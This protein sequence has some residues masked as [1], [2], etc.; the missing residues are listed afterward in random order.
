M[1]PAM[2]ANTVALKICVSGSAAQ[3]VTVKVPS[4]FVAMLSTA[5]IGSLGPAGFFA[6]AGA[7][8]ATDAASPAVT[9]RAA[10]RKRGN[11]LGAVPVSGV[12]EMVGRVIVESSFGAGAAV[13]SPRR[14]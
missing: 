1:R 12:L 13:P 5:P 4:V 7:T 8:T 3:P 9:V 10:A 14:D 11:R 2:K 6:W